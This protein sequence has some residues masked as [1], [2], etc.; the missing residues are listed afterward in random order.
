M[1]HIN[2]RDGKILFSGR[3]TD[4]K[5][6]KRKQ[7]LMFLYN[8]EDE[9]NMNIVDFKLELRCNKTLYIEHKDDYTIKHAIYTS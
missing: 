4:K 9:I 7:S 2:V 5:L 1:S 6:E 8:R 3:L